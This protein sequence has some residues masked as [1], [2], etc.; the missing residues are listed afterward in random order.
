MLF[1]AW[2][3]WACIAEARACKEAGNF[4]EKESIANSSLLGN[5]G[6][7]GRIIADIKQRC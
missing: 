3:A 1:S 2:N 6:V 5:E 7:C 4:F